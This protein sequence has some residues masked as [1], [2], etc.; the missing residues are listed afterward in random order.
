M[1]LSGWINGGLTFVEF[2]SPVPDLQSAYDDFYSELGGQPESIGSVISMDVERSS[3]LV[4]ETWY[5]I[6]SNTQFKHRSGGKPAYITYNKIK[7]TGEPMAVPSTQDEWHYASVVIQY[8][9]HGRLHRPPSSSYSATV[10][11]DPAIFGFSNTVFL[12]PAP[13]APLPPLLPIPAAPE[14]KREPSGVMDYW[15]RG[16][17]LNRA[18]LSYFDFYDA[19]LYNLREVDH[20]SIEAEHDIFYYYDESVTDNAN[21][22][23]GT[24]LL[25]KQQTQSGKNFTLIK[26]YDSANIK[27]EYRSINGSGIPYKQGPGYAEWYDVSPSKSAP[28]LKTYYDLAEIHY[29]I[30]SYNQYDGYPNDPIA[31]QM[32]YEEDGTIKSKSYYRLGTVKCIRDGNG[33]VTYP[34]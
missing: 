4:K 26:R 19:P 7:V 17:D 11:S 31:A 16:V 2:N 32:S 8:Y 5:E 24:A 30:K 13:P 28:K 12:P 3:Y 10:K 33:K 18:T 34:V 6:P 29:P 25:F 22:A 21:S 20:G 15:Y 23:Y 1:A 14:Y 9:E 27:S